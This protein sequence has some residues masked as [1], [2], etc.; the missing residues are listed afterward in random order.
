MAHLQSVSNNTLLQVCLITNPIW[1]VKTRLQ[2]QRRGLSRR[3]IPKGSPTT[4]AVVQYKGFFDGVRR[5]A[6]EEGV[7]GLYRGLGPS[8]VM[9]KLCRG[10]HLSISDMLKLV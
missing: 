2:L 10:M 5:I 8:L 7:R 4:G 6:Q 1:V 9:V 3:A